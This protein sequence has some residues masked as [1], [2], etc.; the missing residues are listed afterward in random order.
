MSGLDAPVRTVVLDDVRGNVGRAIVDCAVEC[1]VLNLVGQKVVFG[2]VTPDRLRVCVVHEL[3]LGCPQMTCRE[4]KVSKK[5]LMV[6]WGLQ[7]AAIA[8]PLGGRVCVGRP[9]GRG[10]ASVQSTWVCT[11]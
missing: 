8:P 3:F 11:P 9:A 10:E 7:W 5:R 6:D 1:R 4:R 2:S